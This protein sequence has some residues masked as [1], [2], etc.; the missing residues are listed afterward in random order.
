MKAII[1]EAKKY[2]N[3][4]SCDI[5]NSNDVDAIDVAEMGMDW[6]EHASGIVQAMY[7]EWNMKSEKDVWE[8]IPWDAPDEEKIR[9]VCQKLLVRSIAKGRRALAS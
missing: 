6:L 2:G 8:M 3:E 7:P 9:E 1:D 4:V 5:L